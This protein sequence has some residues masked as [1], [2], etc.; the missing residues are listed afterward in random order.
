MV[1]GTPFFAVF[2]GKGMNHGRKNTCKKAIMD[3]DNF[4]GNVDNEFH[5][6]T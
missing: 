5:G 1:A 4:N 2:Q 6:R 3:L